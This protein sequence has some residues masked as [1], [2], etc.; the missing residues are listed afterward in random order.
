[1]K[2]KYNFRQQKCIQ[3][4]NIRLK[5]KKK[6]FYRNYTEIQINVTTFK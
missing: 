3:I 4:K 5:K 6:T 2:Q 1:M